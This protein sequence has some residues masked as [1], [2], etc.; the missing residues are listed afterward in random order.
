MPP[1][2]ADAISP[3]VSVRSGGPTP[4]QP[5]PSC[6]DSDS[7]DTVAAG[8]ADAS[9]DVL[10]EDG[11]EFVNLDYDY[12]KFDWFDVPACTRKDRWSQPYFDAGGGGCIQCVY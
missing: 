12:T 9:S 11:Y 8:G 6:C 2:V 4:R 10:I 5:A 7:S 3:T 1:F